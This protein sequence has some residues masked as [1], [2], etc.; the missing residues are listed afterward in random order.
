ML[1]CCVKRSGL[2]EFRRLRFLSTYG[3]EFTDISVV[4]ILV[5]IVVFVFLFYILISLVLLFYNVCLCCLTCELKTF[6]IV[7]QILLK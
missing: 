1:K 2:T 3:Y 5:L 7:P 4:S 6:I